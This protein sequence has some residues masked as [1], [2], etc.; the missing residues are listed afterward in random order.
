[1]AAGASLLLAPKKTRGYVALL[2][3]IR[4]AEVITRNRS[5][6]LQIPRAL[7]AN[8]AANGPHLYRSSPMHDAPR[9]VHGRTSAGLIRTRFNAPRLLSHLV[10][11]RCEEGRQGACCNIYSNYDALSSALSCVPLCGAGDVLLM[12]AA[13]A[14][15]LYCWVFAPTTLEP[16][17]LKFLNRQARSQPTSRHAAI[18]LPTGGQPRS[19]WPP[20]SAARCDQCDQAPCH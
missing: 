4:A 18:P 2:L 16:G 3:A 5:R 9:L 12:C 10:C 6:R 8:G 1:M 7:A 20:T 15:V 11:C 14:P 17:Y 13:S 19:P